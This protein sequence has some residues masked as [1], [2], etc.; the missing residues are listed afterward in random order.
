MPPGG[1]RGSTAVV[2][3]ALE[4]V[5][6]APDCP[7][8][9][10]ESDPDS[11]VVAETL[12]SVEDSADSVPVDS[13]ASVMVPVADSDSVEE[14]AA[15]GEGVEVSD[16]VSSDRESALCVDKSSDPQHNVPLGESSCLLMIKASAFFDESG[17]GHAAAKVMTKR[18]EKSRRRPEPFILKGGGGLTMTFLRC[19]RG[20]ASA[21]KTIRQ[22]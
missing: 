1:N 21:A 10:A 7:E 9:D 8:P 16:G 19:S 11:P 3:D 22:L 15:D 18:N 13:G 4:E 2:L 20:Q 6:E 14:D 12:P 5:L 17:H